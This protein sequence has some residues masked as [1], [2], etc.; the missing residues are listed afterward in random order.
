MAYDRSILVVDDND[1]SL[2]VLSGIIEVAGLR[3]L[4]VVDPTQA[5]ATIE[6]SGAEIMI[7]DIHMPG[8]SGLDLLRQVKAAE[9]RLGR[10]ILVFVITGFSD[11]QKA[12]E[13]LNSG[14][15]AYMTKPLKS[16]ALLL[17]L[18]RAIEEVA[19]GAGQDIDIRSLSGRFERAIFDRKEETGTSPLSPSVAPSA[20]PSAAMSS[21]TGRTELPPSMTHRPLV[22]E[23]IYRWAPPTPGVLTLCDR[24]GA[25]L[26][27]EW[28]DN[29][30]GRLLAYSVRQVGFPD[31]LARAAAFEYCLTSSP[32]MAATLFDRVVNE[33]G[34]FPACQGEAP[35]GS[36]YF[37]CD[38]TSAETGKGFDGLVTGYSRGG[39]PDMLEQVRQ[40][41]AGMPDNP[42]LIEWYAFLLYTNGKYEEAVGCYERLIACG[43]ARAN[44]FFYLGNAL[45]KSGQLVDAVQAWYIAVQQE[46]GSKIGKKAAE[47]IERVNDGRSL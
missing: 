47:R 1:S 44:E 9:G 22:M 7:T 6:S 13:A 38:R 40:L 16:Q 14:A 37:G 3:P 46:P 35:E 4:P 39:D 34:G 8:L 32:A 11:A 41:V 15:F 25:P 30:Q 24:Q 28:S 29:V 23:D 27:V 18:K 12:V 19:A 33:T 36:K 42:E 2:A 26:F 31:L 43:Q 17:H 21:D 20:P 10:R 5:L 45:Y